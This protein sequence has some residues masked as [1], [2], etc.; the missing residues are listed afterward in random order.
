MDRLLSYVSRCPPEAEFLSFGKII[1]KDV[2]SQAQ[3]APDACE[4]LD[5][6]RLSSF[7][8]MK[9]MKEF[10]EG[11]LLETVESQRPLDSV[12]KS[13][14][15]SCRSALEGSRSPEAALRL[16]HTF[17]CSH[18]TDPSKAF[19]GVD[20][21]ETAFNPHHA[22]R[23]GYE[24]QIDRIAN[25][26]GDSKFDPISS[27]GWDASYDQLLQ[28]KLAHSPLVNPSQP[29]LRDL[30]RVCPGFSSLTEQDR[31]KVWSGIFDSMAMAE[32]AHNPNTTFRESFGPLSTGMLQISEAS[33]RDHAGVCARS[34]RADC[35]CGGA[36]T[37]KLKD[38]KFNLACGVTIMENQ[39]ATG[40]GLFGNRSYYWSVLNT[41]Q[42]GFPKVMGRLKSIKSSERWPQACGG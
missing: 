18:S 10:H 11:L 29:M 13:L 2:A 21:A 20:Y 9:T 36:T 37:A 25:D 26:L 23:G 42:N 39:M 1:L 41:T 14:Q 16:L 19:T 12:L 8:F 6:S 17:S 5:M 34:Q 28:Q 3:Q 32:S 15:E 4:Q 7:R 38:P 24:R 27:K 30:E 33:A 35:S 31:A 40:R 22:Q